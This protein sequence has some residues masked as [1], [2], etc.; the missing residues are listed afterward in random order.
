M[1][2]ER[3][4]WGMREGRIHARRVRYARHL[5]FAFA[6]R[7]S[8]LPCETKAIVHLFR[9]TVVHFLR[10]REGKVNSELQRSR[11]A[12]SRWLD[13]AKWTSYQELIVS[14]MSNVNYLDVEN[15]SVHIKIVYHANQRIS[16]STLM[17][18]TVTVS[19]NQNIFLSFRASLTGTLSV[20]SINI[21]TAF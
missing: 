14:Q 21:F 20:L 6:S 19:S 16:V 17:T 11:T 3:E 10:T 12:Y 15:V 5:S 9:K 18:V 13:A 1:R 7:L 8:L 4:G 2:G